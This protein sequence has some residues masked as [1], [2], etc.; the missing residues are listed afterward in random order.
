PLVELSIF[1]LVGIGLF[2]VIFGTF[3][4]STNL[5]YL[6][7]KNYN[8]PR[9]QHG[10][11]LPVNVTDSE[12]HH[13]VIQMLCLGVFLLMISVLSLVVAPQLFIVG[14]TAIFISALVDYSKFRKKDMFIIWIG[15]SIIPSV[16]SLLTA[17]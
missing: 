10:K 11:E 5:L 1:Q 8:L 12:V 16:F 6:I 14:G 4:A 15:I 13:K 3:E 2:G 7:T 9:K 17:I